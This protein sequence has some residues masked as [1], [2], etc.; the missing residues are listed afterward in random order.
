MTTNLLDWHE[1]DQVIDPKAEYRLLLNGLRRTQ[2]F[3][4]FFAQCSTFGGAK[5]IQQVQRDLAV[6]TINVLTFETPIS[7]GNVFKQ[8][9]LFLA[10]HPDT[11]ILFIQG[12]ELSLLD[13]E[14]SKKRL[15]WSSEKIFSYSWQGVPPVLINLNQQREHFRD[16]FSTR[17]VFLL[18]VFAIK[19]LIHRAP[20]FFDWR[21][22]IA[23]FNDDRL[24]LIRETERISLEGDYTQYCLWSQAQRNRRILEIQSVLDADPR[25]EFGRLHLYL[26]Q[27]N[28]FVASSDYEAAIAVYDEALV[29]KPDDHAALHNKGNALY[30]LGRYEEAILA[31]DAAFAIKPDLHEALSQKGAVLGDLGRY[32][33]AI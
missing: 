14:E 31:Y 6:Q 25:V 17:L 16:S 5:I 33:E 28:L 18:P 19:Y 23:Q 11:Q 26:E 4:L 15:G 12:L 1:D 3:G 9:Q 8:V 32:E 10:A 29:I 2:G 13:Y 22:G 21:S 27:G 20:D 24:I 30:K 7:D